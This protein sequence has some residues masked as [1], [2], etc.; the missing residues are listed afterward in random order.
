MRGSKRGLIDSI[1]KLRRRSNGLGTGV[2]FTEKVTLDLGQM[3]RMNGRLPQRE[4]VGVGGTVIGRRNS[5]SGGTSIKVRGMFME[6]TD[7][8]TDERDRWVRVVKNAVSRGRS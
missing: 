5:L 3:L 6:K 4:K 8:K 2:N 7:G 1:G